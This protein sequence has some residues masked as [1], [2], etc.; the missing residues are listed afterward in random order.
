MPPCSIWLIAYDESILQ[1]R[2]NERD[3]VWNHQSHDCLLNC[4][5]R[6]RSRTTSKLRVTGLCA[7]NSPVTG[8]FP[9]QRSSN[10]E[11]VSIWWRHHEQ[12]YQCNHNNQ[13]ITKPC[14]HSRNTLHLMIHDTQIARTLGRECVRSISNWRRTEGLCYLGAYQFAR[15]CLYLN[16]ATSHY[17]NQCRP[18]SL[19]R[20]CGTRGRWVNVFMERSY[21]PLPTV[22]GGSAV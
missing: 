18:S 9:T 13:N 14:V 11:N 22:C 16:Q 8:E 19:T 1:W 20:I 15:V 4:L 5:F 3:D 2:H 17:L 12:W 6:R 10:A 7:G 21:L